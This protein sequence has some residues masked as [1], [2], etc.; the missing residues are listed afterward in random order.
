MT[1]SLI[2]RRA[3]MPRRHLPRCHDGEGDLDWTIVLG[4]GD[5]PA[6]RVQSIH[7]DIL[8]PGASIG[9]HVHDQGEEYYLILS[10][11]GIMTLDGIEHAVGP[12]DLT[13]VFAGGS[14]GLRNT[15]SDDLRV[16][17]WGA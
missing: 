17:V 1:T 9:I 3:D 11:E 16:I 6:R 8:P 2:K 4:D 14:H 5:P 13:A 10:G 15:G 12:G 7:D